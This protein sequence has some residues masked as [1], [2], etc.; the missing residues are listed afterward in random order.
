MAGTPLAS[1]YVQVRADTSKV[2]GDI[3]DG[4]SKAGD[5]AE[6]HGKSSGAKFAAAAGVAIAAGAIAFGKDSV[7]AYVEA[8]A[9]QNRLADAF[10]KFPAL[11]DTNQQAFQDL[12]GEIQKKT[13]FDD[14]ALASGQA[15]LAQ[16]G[17][18]GKQVA[19]LQR[20]WFCR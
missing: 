6:K 15:T 5:T 3:D 2:K 13:R 20:C 14:D 1:A 16:F 17:L 4:F 19:E 9:S 8:E 18:T 7:D 11:A 12:N 10:K